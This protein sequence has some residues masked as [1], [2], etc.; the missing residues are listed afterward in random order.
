MVW[1]VRGTGNVQSCACEYHTWVRGPNR[2]TA[3]PLLE[4]YAGLC[5]II[6][7]PEISRGNYLDA[8]DPCNTPAAQQE[9]EHEH[10]HEQKQKSTERQFKYRCIEDE[11][12][13][14]KNKKPSQ[15]VETIC[16][17]KPLV[18]PGMM[19]LVI[20]KKILTYCNTAPWANIIFSVNESMILRLIAS[21]LS[22]IVGKD[23][24]EKEK[25]SL[26]PIIDPSEDLSNTQNVVW[27][28]NR[29]QGKTSTLAKFLAV[30]SMLSPTGG[31]L[32]CV[33]ST[34]LDRAQELT[35]AAKKYIYW[36]G[37]DEKAKAFLETIGVQPPILTK[38][39][40]RS[41]T[42]ISEYGVRNTVNSRPK[43]PDSCRG[44][45]P[46]GN[47]C[48]YTYA[49]IFHFKQADLAQVRHL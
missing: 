44:D 48:L 15:L 25:A 11:W 13:S 12:F 41:Y 1:C 39:N 42:V 33:Y 34:S 14:H 20:F 37:S 29:Q 32:M 23:Y 36:L 6:K 47:T 16:I 24:W 45:A 31:T 4:C 19:R 30:L 2:A 18:N 3:V 9:Q 5:Q 28:T 46:K 10:E 22:L 7:L 27:V 21:H 26:Y 35:R 49:D 38:D 43:N 17:A 40:E 8:I